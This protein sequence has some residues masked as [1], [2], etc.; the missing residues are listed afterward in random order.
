VAAAGLSEEL[1]R[2]LSQFRQLH[3]ASEA[4]VANVSA[5]D[6]VEKTAR[7]LGV[8]LIVD[9]LVQGSNHK[10]SIIVNL[11]D[12]PDG[13]KL[14]SQ[15]FSRLSND[16]LALEDQ[17]SSELVTA[18]NFN[19]TNEEL[20]RSSAHPTE[21]LAAYD[22]YLRGRSALRGQHRL[23][24]NQNAAGFPAQKDPT[25]N[26]AAYDVYLR[27]RM[28]NGQAAAALFAQAVQKDPNFVLAY[29]GLADASLAIY[30]SRQD[31][32]WSASALAAALRARELNDDEPKVHFSLAAVYQSTGKNA[33]AIS[34][35]KRALKLEPN[36][37]DGYRALGAA[38][39]STHL[40]ADAIAAHQKAIDLNPY[41]WL[42][43]N[44]IGIAYANFG[45]MDKALAAF[46]KIAEMGPDNSAAFDNAGL[47]LLRQG[48]YAESIPEFE[49]A[50]SLTVNND[51]AYSNL[52]YAYFELKRYEDAVT[53]FERAVQL[54]PTD[55]INMGNLADG[56]RWSGQKDKATATYD[57][58]IELAYKDLQA[59][60][61]SA[62]TLSSLALYYAKKGQSVQAL[63][64]IR[65]ARLLDKKNVDFMYDE[66]EIQALA[67]RPDD[68]LKLLRQALQKGASFTDAKNDPELGSL[69]G[70]PEFAELER[71]FAKPLDSAPTETESK[72]E[73]GLDNLQLRAL[74]SKVTAHQPQ[75]PVAH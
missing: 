66:A 16:L 47:I 62:T 52:G 69:Q 73:S 20:A 12:V 30:V 51:V 58:A 43:Y 36:S 39:T 46:R 64:F 41:F 1:I 48:K 59:N 50:I 17:I 42:N 5:K 63:S 10:V 3:L 7:H 2:K 45:D 6:S 15:Q 29:S 18:I 27:D 8:N 53:N 33:E 44:A 49:K 40:Y 21:S 22:L 28:W 32:F 38:Y 31:E 68:A 4:D 13:K 57:K 67:N 11:R 34:E 74:V 9:G 70:R 14:W 56:Y 71:E 37:D 25:E 35:L 55:S 61:R 26:I 19:I 60:P 72:S 24:E 23:K 54:N 65:R 75:A